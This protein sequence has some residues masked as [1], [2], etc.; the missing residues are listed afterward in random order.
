MK[1]TLSIAAIAL[2]YF[3]N[4]LAVTKKVLYI[5]NSYIYTNDVPTLVKN[6]AL[7]NGDT[8]IYDQNTIGGY[9]FESHSTN[10]VTISKIAAQKWDIVVLQEQSQRPSFDPSQVAVEVYPYARKLD[11]MIHA[12]DTC[13]ETA[14]LMTWG[15]P[16]GDHSN[17]PFYP[18]VCTYAGMQQ[19]LRESYMEMAVDNHGIVAPVGMA[20][21]LMLDSA[22]A[23]WLYS[24]DSSHPSLAGAYIEACV[25]YSTIFHKK[26][27]N[28]SFISSLTSTE[29][30]LLQ[31]V[32]DK[33]VFDSLS[34]W[35]GNGN[36]PY[37]GFSY[38][39]T[40]SINFNH[41]SPVPVNHFWDFGDGNTDTA[42]N[43]THNFATVL[44]TFLVT[45]T[46]SNDCFTETFSDS[47]HISDA[48]INQNTIGN[49]SILI[50]Q[51]DDSKVIFNFNNHTAQSML[52]VYDISG[53][54]LKQWTVNGTSISERFTP[55]LY[56]YKYTDKQTNRSISGK[57]SCY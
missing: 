42:A 55:G 29:A 19:R 51:T 16:T 5:G 7:A 45:H 28:N 17:C 2:L 52:E 34:L 20:W 56:I 43:P 11:S 49:T 54:K 36:Y 6:I 10:A 22:Y 46:V 47:V 15:R 53:K 1:K 44:G 41:Q 21:K 31:R 13:T 33:I 9:T 23:P 57:F 8:V 25:L 14:F 3:A 39:G 18:P 37:A 12:N 24:P 32:S 35:Q 26:T 48:G 4:A 30:K 50:A 38:S 40:V 27:L